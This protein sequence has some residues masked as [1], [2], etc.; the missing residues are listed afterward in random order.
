MEEAEQS[1]I[2][3]YPILKSAKAD[4]DARIKQYETAKRINSPSLDLSV[5]YRWR[6][7]AERPNVTPGYQED[8]TA[9]A[10]VRFNIFNGLHDI[11]RIRQTKFEINEAE[12][13]MNSTKRQLV[14]SI[15]LSYEAYL[16]AQDR[17]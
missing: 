5:D 16:A 17:C 12:E 2:N 8:L 1:A 3:N 11:A 9:M 6:D 4:L 14:Q 15:R 7:D 10:T 13:I